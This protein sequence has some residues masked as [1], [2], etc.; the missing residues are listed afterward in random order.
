MGEGGC[1]VHDGHL[2]AVLVKTLNRNSGYVTNIL[3]KDLNV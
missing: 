2:G 3:S 1:N